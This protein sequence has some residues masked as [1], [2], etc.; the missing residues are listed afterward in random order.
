MIQDTTSKIGHAERVRHCKTTS[1]IMKQPGVV[2]PS[3]PVSGCWHLTLRADR[4]PDFVCHFSP[5]FFWRHKD[6]FIFRFV[7]NI[8]INPNLLALKQDDRRC[9]NICFTCLTV[10]PVFKVCFLY[11]VIKCRCYIK[12][13]MA[14]RGGLEDVFLIYNFCSW[15][16]SF[17]YCVL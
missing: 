6:L 2:C 17:W 4:A 1:W 13:I 5:P 11:F 14:S 10:F 8:V 15:R 16:C 12:H 3:F 7:S 9:E